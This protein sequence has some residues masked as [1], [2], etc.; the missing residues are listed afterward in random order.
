MGICQGIGAVYRRERRAANKRT[1]S[2]DYSKDLMLKAL[3]RYLRSIYDEAFADTYQPWYIE[4]LP[5]LLMFAGL[6]LLLGWSFIIHNLF[7]GLSIF[8]RYVY[9]IAF[10]LFTISGV[11]I[12]WYKKAMIFVRGIPAVMI[13]VV[14][15]ASSGY[16][17]FYII[18]LLLKP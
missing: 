3:D 12:I 18:Q 10:S 13:G 16:L 8:S 2:W 7:P 6:S 15:V 9:L 1:L 17:V 5:E 14:M 11:T 4:L